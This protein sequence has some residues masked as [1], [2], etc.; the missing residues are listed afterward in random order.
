M[1]DKTGLNS[2]YDD[3]TIFV[4]IFVSASVLTHEFKK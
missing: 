1:N 2:Y 3:Y 4:N